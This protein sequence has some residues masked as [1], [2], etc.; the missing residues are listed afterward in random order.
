MISACV[1]P[2]VKHGGGGVMVWGWFSGETVCDWFRIQG[3]F[4]QHGYHSILQ[5]Y[6]V[7]SDLHLVGLSFVSQQDKDTHLYLTKK[8]WWSAASDDLTST[9]T[10][11]DPKWDGLGWVGCRVK[12]KQS[13]CAQHMWELLQD[14][15][16]SIPG[17]AG[18]NNAKIVQSCDVF[19]F[20]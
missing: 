14:C 2:T 9:I 3:T 16:K 4:N 12:E 18:W 20:V 13:T 6:A 7:P 15:W 1:V 10:Q 19:R 11:P 17:E 8:E 5:R